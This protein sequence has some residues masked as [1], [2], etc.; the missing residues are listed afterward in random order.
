VEKSFEYTL[1]KIGARVKSLRQKNALTQSALAS[2]CDIDIRS[3][4][5]IEKGEMNM[6]LKLCF[7]LALA[8]DINICELINEEGHASKTC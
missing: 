1:V 8:F 4:Q 5:R 3:I 7:H 6:S 2:R